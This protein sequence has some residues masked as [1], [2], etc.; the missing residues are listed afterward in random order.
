MRKPNVD[1]FVA[2][3]PE[4]QIG[5][6]ADVRCGSML[7]K[8]SLFEGHFGDALSGLYV[9]SLRSNRSRTDLELGRSAAS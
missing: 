2:A 1:R 4:V 8:N 7:S 3:I 9:P 5:R 6:E